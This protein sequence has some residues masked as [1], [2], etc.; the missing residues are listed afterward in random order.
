[1]ES[2]YLTGDAPAVNSLLLLLL[3]LILILLMIFGECDV[4]PRIRSMIRIRS[5]KGGHIRIARV[6]RL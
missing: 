1:L 3:L 2:G 4:P 5:R 6:E